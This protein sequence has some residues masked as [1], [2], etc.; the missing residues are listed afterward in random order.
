MIDKHTRMKNPDMKTIEG[1]RTAI[2]LE[3]EGL[4]AYLRFARQ[5]KDETGKNMFIILASDEVDHMSILEK[6]LESHLEGGPWVKVETK[7]SDIQ[8]IL[9][10]IREKAPKTEGKS[11]LH[12]VDALRMALDFEKRSMD[13]YTGQAGLT[14]DPVAKE[15]FQ[16]LA[17]MEEAHYEII[18]AELDSIGRTG[19]WFNVPEFSLELEG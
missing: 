3:K 4:R 16:K 9:P 10:R 15:L 11:G 18:Q 19:F 7:D 5:T 1:L 17:R 6:Q 14:Q 13:F 8:K 12:Q 2:Q